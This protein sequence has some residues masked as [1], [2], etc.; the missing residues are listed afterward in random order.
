M[1]SIFLSILSKSTINTYLF[2]FLAKFAD[3]LYHHR[4]LD[5][6]FP[7]QNKMAERVPHAGR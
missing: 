7:R 3:D 6:A 1:Q 2:I 4:G 5:D